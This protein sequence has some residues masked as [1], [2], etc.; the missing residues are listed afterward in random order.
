MSPRAFIIGRVIALLPA[1]VGCASSGREWRVKDN[2]DEYLS[3]RYVFSCKMGSDGEREIRREHGC[4]IVEGNLVVVDAYR[5]WCV[6]ECE[7]WQVNNFGIRE[8]KRSLIAEPP[9]AP[10]AGTTKRISLGEVPYAVRRT[11]QVREDVQ[12]VDL[13]S[14]EL[15]FQVSSS[16]V[17][18]DR[19]LPADDE[20][21]VLGARA[22]LKPTGAVSIFLCDNELKKLLGETVSQFAVLVTADAPAWKDSFRKKPPSKTWVLRQTIDRAMIENAL[23]QAG[24]RE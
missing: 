20:Y 24:S 15:I 12:A 5:T 11:P 8:S 22:D 3:T 23:F 14:V 10:Y 18:R 16:P 13:S 2:G 4:L 21:F 17:V 9:D 19:P 6:Y 1:L 7:E